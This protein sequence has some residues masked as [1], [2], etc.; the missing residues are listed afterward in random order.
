M[1]CYKCSITKIVLFLYP[2]KY[3]TSVLG[4]LSIHAPGMVQQKVSQSKTDDRMKL[5]SKLL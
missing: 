4:T 2:E 5:K 3:I 1:Y